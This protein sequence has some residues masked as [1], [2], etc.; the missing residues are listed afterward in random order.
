MT[1]D[2]TP[3]VY[4]C[5]KDICCSQIFLHPIKRAAAARQHLSAPAK[6]QLSTLQAQPNAKQDWSG[7]VLGKK[8]A[9]SNILQLLF[10]LFLC[11]KDVSIL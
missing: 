4:L 8:N 1:Q 3:P 10:C 6:Q 11:Q 7:P 2:V 9:D 5:R